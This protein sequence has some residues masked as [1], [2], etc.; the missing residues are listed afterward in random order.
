MNNKYE[1]TR[2]YRK[3]TLKWSLFLSLVLL[4]LMTVR[5]EGTHEV[6]PNPT[7]M[8]ML[9]VGDG[10]YGNFATLGSPEGSRLFVQLNSATEVL[11]LGL[12]REYNESGSPA[13]TGNY[14]YRIRRASNDEI[15]HGPYS[16][17]SF[18]ENVSSWEDA[19]GPAVLNNGVGYAT[20]DARFLFAPGEAGLYYIEFISVDHIGYWDFTVADNGVEIPGRVFSRN[21][22]FRTPTVG[23]TQ[24]ECV[25]DRRFNGKLYSYTTD[26][27]VTQID[28]ADSG[29]QGLS[30]TMAFN[31]SGPG[32]TGDLG[33]DR[34]SIPAENVTDD[35]AEHLVFL[36]P[37]D[38][39][40][41]PDGE[42]GELT[43]APF[44]NCAGSEAYCLD[45]TVTQPGQV[46]VILD[47][48]ENGVFDIDIDRRLLHRFLPGQPLS[49]CLS[50]DGLLGDGTPVDPGTQLNLS[51]NYTQGIQHWAV[52]D[53]E[54]LKDG[55]CV[56]PI[57]PL[58]TTSG[59]TDILYWDDRNIID[60]PGT[61]QPKDGRGGCDCTTP[62][63]RT[64]NNFNP[65]TDDCSMIND[66]NTT[67]YGDKN[68]LNTWWFANVFAVD[69]VGVPLISVEIEAETEICEGETTTLGVNFFSNAAIAEL[70]WS[71]PD[72]II[73]SGPDAPEEIEV[74]TPGTYTLEIT[75]QN[76]CS[77]TDTHELSQFACPTDLEL[78]IDVDSPL[79][80]IGSA[81]TFTITVT[82]QGPFNAGGFTVNTLW[83]VGL[84]NVVPL[85]A[86][87]TLN[88]NTIDWEN[89]SLEVGESLTLTFMGTVA[90]AFDYTILAE[91]TYSA[92]GDPD[93]TPGNGVDTNG[94]N[95]C[96]DDAGDED[97]GDCVTMVPPACELDATIAV[98]SVACD[99]NGTPSD[100]DDDV[101][102]FQLVVSG[103][104]GSS[105]WRTLVNGQTVTGAY[106]EVVTVGPLAI[107][108]GD[109]ELIITDGFFGAACSTTLSIPAPTTCS[110]QCD[111]AIEASSSVCNDN[112]T[113]YDP[114][115]DT[116]AFTFEITGANTS[117][118]WTA[119]D[120][121][122]GNYGTSYT[123]ENN[124]LSEGDVTLT[125]TDSEDNTCSISHTFEAPAETCSPDCFLDG[126]VGPN[127]C[128]DNGTPSDP[129][130]DTFTFT[131]AITG[132]NTSTT[133]WSANDPNNTA[134]TYGTMITMGPYPISGGSLDF[135]VVDPGNPDCNLPLFIVLPS[136]CSNDCALSVVTT[137]SICNDNGTSYDPADDTFAFTFEI[138]GANASGSWTASDGSTGNYG[139][140]YTY[141][142]NPLSEGDV[143]LT[144]TDS[145][146]NTCSISHT[147]EAPAETCS[148]DCFLDGS[149]GPNICDNNG[150]PSDASDD[151]FTF[152]LEVTGYNAS[153]GN[154]LAN[155]PNNTSGAYGTTMLMG[156]YPISGGN[157][158]FQVFDPGNPDCNLPIFIVPPGTCSDVCAL[159]L[160]Q[161][162]I[163]CNDNGTPFDGDD[164]TYTILVRV[165]AANGGT[166]WTSTNG[167]TGLYGE[168]VTL[169]PFPISGGNV[170]LTFTDNEVPGC[171]LTTSFVAPPS[172]STAC[173][174]NDAVVTNVVCNDNDTP[175][176]P[177]DDT[178]TFSVTVTGDNL[179]TNWTANDGTTGAYD[180][181]VAF[182]PYTVADGDVDLG[183]TDSA[184]NNCTFSLQ[185]T[186]PT[187]CS[188]QCAM[189][190]T[191]SNYQC[192][193]NGTPSDPDDD[194][195]TFDLLAEGVNNNGA[196]WIQ[197]SG[198]SGAYGTAIT[199]G[200]FLISDGAFDM[201]IQDVEDASCTGSVTIMPPAPCSFQCMVITTLNTVVCDDAGTPEDS[202][203]DFYVYTILVDGVN[204]SDSWIANDGT[205]GNY[206]EL[207]ESVPHSYSEGVLSVNISDSVADCGE[208][209][210]IN[211]PTPALFC[212]E[213]TS[214]R[215]FIGSIQ[216]LQGHLDQDDLVVEEAPCF[217]AFSSTPILLGDRF[218]E[219]VDVT[220]PGPIDTADNV[221]SFF[222]FSDIPLSPELEDLGDADGAGML[223]NGSYT[224]YDDPCCFN[225][226][227]PDELDNNEDMETIN[228]MIDTTGMFSQDMHLV[229]HFTQSLKPSQN[230]SLVAS[231]YGIEASGNYAWVVV[232]YRDVPMTVNSEE[233]TSTFMPYDTLS[234]DLTYNHILWTQ[235]NSASQATVGYPSVEPLC[236]LDSLYFQDELDFDDN[237]ADAHIYRTFIMESAGQPD[238]CD[239][240]LTFRRPTIDDIVLPPATATFQCGDDYGLNEN[241]YPSPQDT[242]YPLV[243]GGED[244]DTLFNQT[245]IFNLAVSYKDIPNPITTDLI[246]DLTREWTITDVC[247]GDTLYII[248]QQIKIGPFGPPRLVCP[249]GGDGC[250]CPDDNVLVYD[251]DP[252]DCTATV[253]IPLAEL[254]G[255]CD[256]SRIDD[257]TIT[258]EL[259]RV[260]DDELI[261]T[262]EF[263][264]ARS[265][266]NLETGDYTLHYI[267]E[268]LDG[269]QIES[270]CQMRIADLQVPTAICRNSLTVTVEEDNT[271]LLYPENLDLGSYD[272]CEPPSLLMRRFYNEGTDACAGDM[273]GTFGDWTGELAFECCDA[274]ETFLVELQ[275]MDADSN[276]NGCN[277]MITV[278]DDVAPELAGLETL[279]L[280]CSALPLGFEPMDSVQRVA[281]FGMPEVTDNCT[282]EIVEMTPELSWDDCDLGSIRRLFMA[283]D[284]AGNTT[285]EVYEQMITI[286]RNNTY[287]IR[288]PKDEMTDCVAGLETLEFINGGCGNFTVTYEDVELATE[289]EECLRLARTYLIV[290]D[291]EYDGE[292]TP[293]VLSRN[294]N[295][296]VE[297]GTEDVWLVVNNGSAFADADSEAFNQFP[298]AGQNCAT[299][300][301]GYW[302]D[303]PNVGAWEYTQ[304][305][306][307]QDETAP[308]VAF[309]TPAAFCTTDES[310]EGLVSI[311]VELEDACLPE[312]TEVQLFLDQD[313]DGTNDLDL[314]ETSVLTRTNNSFLI[315]GNFPVG[316][317]AFVFA[318]TDGCNNLSSERIAFTVADCFVA[319][320]TCVTAME[321]QLA[322]VVPATDLNGDGIL[323]EAAVILSA[324][325]L[326]DMAEMDCSGD[327][328]YSVNLP[329]MTADFSAD[330]LVLT[331]EDRYQAAREIVVRDNANNPYALQPDGSTGGPN[332]QHC[333]VII[334]VQDAN[335]VCSACAENELEIEGV[336]R[337]R[338][339][340][341][342]SGVE[343][344]LSIDDIFDEN[345]FTIDD[346][347]FEFP[348]LTFSTNYE[349]KPYKNDDTGNGVTTLDLIIL[350]RHLLL[351]QI[352]TDPYVLLAADIT[353]DGEVTTLDLLWMQ[354]L[355]LGRI[356][357]F[358]AN[359]S[360]RFVPS[361]FPLTDIAAEIPDSYRYFNLLVCQFA[362][363]FIGIKIGDLN[364]S[365][366]SDGVMAQA[367]DRTNGKWLLEAPDYDLR[368]GD[369]YRIPIRANNL[370]QLSGLEVELALN[371]E[372]LEVLE[373]EEGQ[374]KAEQMNTALMER[375]LLKGIWLAQKTSS[376]EPLFTLVV[377]AKADA[378]LADV[379]AVSGR[380]PSIAYDHALAEYDLQLQFNDY[381]QEAVLL[382][383]HP[384]PFRETTQISFYLPQAGNY[385]L[386]ITDATGKVLQ[387]YQQRADAG[388]QQQAIRGEGL[389][390]GVLFYTLT[391]DGR[392]ISRRMVK[393]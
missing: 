99:S 56:E 337:T 210:E 155:D 108:S 185:V 59:Q 303:L 15:I 377:A 40:V 242:G 36:A 351:Q 316:D 304:V 50:W 311:V 165:T 360:W 269:N 258:T 90:P 19:S 332:Y 55:F 206:G 8:V 234:E 285:A 97:D 13:S 200:P 77:F 115:D 338:T 388:K 184:D 194:L 380:V 378:K 81:I 122:T 192:L 11:Y 310:C 141:E 282:A 312:R 289:G 322:P 43:V 323:D 344:Q 68:S 38:P 214:Q 229:N 129:S 144:F 180:T 373:V 65:Q 384:D 292:S 161:S 72:G 156:P 32:Q 383:N 76:G 14:S 142:N 167:Q 326:A 215:N 199:Q 42:C 101:F 370:E 208:T 284:G 104:N 10:N 148:P 151:I 127:I 178:F 237:C 118:S 18:V 340:Q 175:V 308:V 124:P 171:A 309:G 207:V 293:T 324:A 169:G 79:A 204:T 272:N 2:F 147:F 251:V 270:N 369:I 319:T 131:L 365:V 47:I 287:R 63:C 343:V 385:L 136:S 354:Q 320:P 168:W 27:F 33:I 201:V 221:Y 334:S 197:P 376:N 116:F 217:L 112:G 62:G 209:I 302:R 134:G 89:L 275:V 224:G 30:F 220:T 306:S 315:E 273:A 333:T 195:F 355:L 356:E 288:F 246:L 313:N 259:I 191:V 390:A 35:F 266:A 225:V 357:T 193:D 314:T 159:T 3:Y 277:V 74:N 170:S 164:D 46:E 17:N 34:M 85:S 271:N 212:P 205:T 160:Q 345:S 188:D 123:Y 279:T 256:E 119:S 54:F 64:W 367:E 342:M 278:I 163:Q 186:A 51:V 228:P 25:W 255:F 325:L 166:S 297:E 222:F 329:G 244:Y 179:G 139:T 44:F 138:T 94:N 73:A 216:I 121:S 295:C 61:G 6:A 91:I 328:A 374:V 172:C 4:S 202:S 83:P 45:V 294:E 16:I 154:W 263:D 218:M 359:T 39:A 157:I 29:L 98:S 379:L 133:A 111:L 371:T 393:L 78:D 382:K 238:S 265:V 262:I 132:Y 227:Y 183:F 86:G 117:G 158:D 109:L 364:G 331:C 48:N 232:S 182:G 146:D 264:G 149:V 307:I 386:E 219:P 100:P 23:N 69:M 152:T 235:G 231:T 339:N 233:V 381:G 107:A 190:V 125:F 358:P 254:V 95:Q 130:D 137:N 341:P 268:D 363:D 372:V 49:T 162:L 226:S 276:I 346:G 353:N 22:A 366:S 281:L 71:G 58:C 317:H 110:D 286:N 75:D 375:G 248:P 261:E 84:V 7:D 321:V 335:E 31:S 12:S 391:F 298:P 176:D 348:Q 92:Q 239:Q 21:W 196:G 305:I 114:A 177:T 249:I 181:P 105:G 1:T 352:I 41:F 260:V 350:Q 150:T 173:I 267:A 389:P 211:P 128:N 392:Q 213:D 143:T 247:N 250:S 96:A 60:D 87:G 52:Y 223:F 240:Q 368:A 106:D 300:P 203:D 67:G 102:T 230:Y 113:S 252:L 347:K 5:A 257:W 327:Y 330:N 296:A 318:A 57:R 126:S 187:S 236:G 283:T 120:G 82:N 145:E 362:Q 37:P 140:S 299:N 70:T 20:D 241:G 135:L 243:S 93:S 66:N 53:T 253:D 291:C 387:Q 103:S 80:D 349:V 245:T 24:P 153:S 361:E 174:I 336:I 28:F 301:A 290:N 9:L 274:G 189:E 280:P 26:G 198:N 88:G